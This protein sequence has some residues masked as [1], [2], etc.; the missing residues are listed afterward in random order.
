MEVQAEN[1]VAPFWSD[2]DMASDSRVWYH[3]YNKFSNS[4]SGILSQAQS[5]VVQ[6]YRDPAVA[7]G[8]DPNTALVV[9]WERVYPAPANMYPMQVC[10]R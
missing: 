9:T 6:G 3:F 2:I 1:M 8:F 4:S 5:L 7:A 10:P